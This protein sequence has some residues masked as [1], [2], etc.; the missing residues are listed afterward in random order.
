MN[1]NINLL[2]IENSSDDASLLLCLITD[3]HYSVKYH[4]VGTERGLRLA[5][6]GK[7][8]WDL[9][10][11]EHNL[12]RLNSDRA[13][14]I[15]KKFDKD[16]PVIVVSGDM[17]EEQAVE[18]MR[19]G[20]NDY[21][22]KN[23]LQRLVPAIERELKDAAFRKMQNKKLNSLK[24]AID[25]SHNIIFVTDID[26]KI[27]NMNRRFLEM[28]GLSSDSAIGKT[29]NVFNHHREEEG[30]WHEQ[31]KHVVVT[32]ESWTGD[33][34][35]RNKDGDL[36]WSLV[37]ISPVFEN[38]EIVSLVNVAEDFSKYKE[39]EIELSEKALHDSLTQLPNR[40]L[41]NEQLEQIFKLVARNNGSAALLSLDL[42][43]FKLIND[44][45]G[46]LQGDNFLIEM[47]A[48]LKSCVRETDL[49]ARIGGDEFCILLRDINNLDDADY[50]VQKIF[51]ALE[52]PFQLSSCLHYAHVSIGVAFIPMD[53]LT[54][55]E[56]RNN[57]DLAMYQ[58]KYLGRVNGKNNYVYYN[59]YCSINK[60]V[61]A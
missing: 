1:K 21:L 35:C 2:F 13:I 8:R 27:E 56:V 50:I 54:P 17:G 16:L 32:K 43:N 24:A 58:A 41:F 40:F 49:I 44:T 47:A 14:A 57:S 15:V 36:F 33:V 37:S 52:T 19:A 12:F 4:I 42:D 26:G 39:Q 46:H 10:I 3:A 38:G 60:E 29:A 53:G 6:N 5:L 45:F 25:Q 11:S 51:Q 48:R 20:A 59:Q 28:S 34:L 31:L 7:T 61:V 22:L 23:N 30:V 55:L 9:V 18:A